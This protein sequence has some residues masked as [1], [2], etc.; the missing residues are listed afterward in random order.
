[1]KKKKKKKK[2]TKKTKQNKKTPKNMKKNK[3]AK[4]KGGG[5]KKEKKSFLYRFFS[6]PK[7]G[8]RSIVVTKFLMHAPTH[9]KEFRAQTKDFQLT[10]EGLT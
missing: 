5:E 6:T 8:S 1:M 4:I 3:E 2:K 10:Y 7:T 9:W